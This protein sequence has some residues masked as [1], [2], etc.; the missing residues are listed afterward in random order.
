MLADG[1]EETNDEEDWSWEEVLEGSED[2]VVELAKNNGR[3]DRRPVVTGF[4]SL[5]VRTV[6]ELIENSVRLVT[7][8]ALV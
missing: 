2:R 5:M 6:E 8:N 4:Q 3:A 7:F 1:S